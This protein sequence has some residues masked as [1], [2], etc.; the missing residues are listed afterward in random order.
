MAGINYRLTEDLLLYAN[1]STA[2]QTPTTT[3]LSN[4]PTGQGGFNP[5]LQPELISNYEVGVRGDLTGSPI[6]YD[7]SVYRLNIDQ[8][9]IPYQLPGSQSDVLYYRNTGNAINNGLELMLNWIPEDP[10][11]IS[12]SYNLM[13]FK[14]TNFV[15]DFPVTNG[16][17]PIQLDGKR[18]PGMP[19][20][21]LTSNIT[22]KIISGLTAGFTLNWTGKYFVNDI[23]GPVPGSDPNA[24]DYI[25]D[26]YV[27]ANVQLTYNHSFVT[28]NLNAYMCIENIFNERYNGS[29]VPNATGDKYFEPGLPRYW[30]GGISFGFL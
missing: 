19:E 9:L 20:N 28:G 3:E 22:C 27:T 17:V 13:D 29:I 14:Y 18:V 6:I 4:S 15:E 11:S 7:A 24:S 2:F 23:N 21:K 1:Y 10:Y 5:D 8:I 26:A 30:Y 16:T 12:L 25:N